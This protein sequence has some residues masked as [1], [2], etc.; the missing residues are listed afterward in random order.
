[1]VRLYAFEPQEA[2]DLPGKTSLSAL[3]SSLVMSR[4]NTYGVQMIAASSVIPQLNPDNSYPYPWDGADL[5]F[6]VAETLIDGQA[7][8]I[9]LIG[10]NEYHAVT[11][12]VTPLLSAVDFDLSSFLGQLKDEYSIVGKP[13][14]ISSVETAGV[15]EKLVPSARSR[16][17]AEDLALK[18]AG[19]ICD[20]ASTDYLS[21]M[22][23]PEEVIA[24]CLRCRAFSGTP[25]RIVRFT[26]LDFSEEA[27]ASLIDTDED[28][29]AERLDYIR[30]TVIRQQGTIL[31]SMIG[32][33][34]IAASS[35]MTAN[36]AASGLREESTVLWL[37]YE[38]EDKDHSF[39]FVLAV[40]VIKNA[41]D[42][43]DLTAAPIY[44]SLT[45]YIL[46]YAEND[47][48]TIDDVIKGLHDMSGR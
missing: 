39:P 8:A 19:I 26:D 13:V 37:C 25:S 10:F 23:T 6:Y 30:R 21:S 5:P 43:Y 42:C 3:L 32:S 28:L 35:I 41:N 9:T 46:P 7:R 45:D 40:S 29:S 47:T 14:D 15:L 36:L 20:K 38:D 16:E 12:S 18:L 48:L 44:G 27:L 33:T 34:A 4:I 17:T 2:A 1:M 22:N 11:A 24:F 31:N